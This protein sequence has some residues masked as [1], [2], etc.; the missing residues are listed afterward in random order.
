MPFDRP[1]DTRTSR[2]VPTMEEEFEARAELL[3]RAQENL[4][5]VTEGIRGEEWQ[6]A[7]WIPPSNAATMPLKG[8]FGLIGHRLRGVTADIRGIPKSQLDRELVKT[9]LQ[10]L[11]RYDPRFMAESIDELTFK[12]NPSFNLEP[13]KFYF[14]SATKTPDRGAVTIYTDTSRLSPKTRADVHR[15]LKKTDTPGHEL[16]HLFHSRIRNLEQFPVGVRRKLRDIADS[17]KTITGYGPAKEA[18]AGMLEDMSLQYQGKAITDKQ[19][20]QWVRDAAIS[21]HDFYDLKKSLK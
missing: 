10:R 15:V 2:P 7:S 16:G 19:F 11:H 20:K 17:S 9:Q 12:A 6:M 21:V 8:K 3:Q 13:E 5:L 4:A 14:G 1:I 18:F